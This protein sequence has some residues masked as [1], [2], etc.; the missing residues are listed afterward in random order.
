MHTGGIIMK[1]THYRQT[2]D[3]TSDRPKVHCWQ[4]GPPE[5]GLRTFCCLPDGHRGKCAYVSE[6]RITLVIRDV[7]ASE[8]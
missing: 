4:E 2:A 5:D 8:K 1:A 6:D 3:F 7:A